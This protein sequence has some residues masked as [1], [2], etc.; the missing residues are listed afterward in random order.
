MSIPNLIT[1]SRLLIG[2]T[3]WAI[4]TYREALGIPLPWLP[5]ILL[6][7]LAVSELSDM[8]DGYLARRFD[9]VSDLGKILDPM[10]DSVSR[11]SF[12]LTFIG[13]P[14]GLPIIWVMLLFYRDAVISTLRTVCALKGFALAA[15]WTGKLKAVVQALA[16]L[17]ILLTMIPYSMGWCSLGMLRQVSTT[18]V[19]IATG[20]TL[21]TA[22][23]YL[24]ANRRF[25][26]AVLN[27]EGTSVYGDKQRAET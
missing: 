16:T 6:G 12:F 14:V 4:Y 18:A 10:A 1:A 25:I 3:F 19:A 5:L 23:D 27:S 9:Q 11:I 22:V 17:T 8:M 7:V 21:L 24:I 26:R 2:P 13:D 15:R 20:Y